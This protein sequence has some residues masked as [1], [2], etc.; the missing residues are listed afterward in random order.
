MS[1]TAL[2]VPVHSLAE[3]ISSE[4]EVRELEGIT[5]LAHT[6][7][8]IFQ[9]NP[10]RW[11]YYAACETTPPPGFKLSALAVY[12]QNGLAAAAPVFRVTYALDMPLQGRWRPLGE[13]LART[14]PRIANIPVIGLGSPLADACHI[15]FAQ[16]LSPAE[17]KRA[18]AHLIR[19]LEVIAAREHI[20]I[21]AIK[22][23]ETRDRDLLEGTIAEAG[24]TTT[25]AL[26]I[27][28][29][30]LSRF[31]SVDD[32]LA[33]LSAATRK[34]IRRKLKCPTTIRC[35]I[36]HDIAGIEQEIVS[37]YDETRGQSGVDYGDFEK[38][39]PAYFRAVLDKLQPN[40]HV[41]LYWLDSRLI[42]FN[43]VLL[44]R[45]RMIDKFI[46]LRYPVACE[47]SLY[48]RSWMENVRYCL[49]HG[50]SVLQ[51]GQTAYT[52]KVRYGSRLDPR[53]ICF[54][55]RRPFWNWVFAKA[56][57]MVAFDKMD[58]ELA[59]L[60]KRQKGRGAQPTASDTHP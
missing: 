44:D 2:T 57:P 49:A 54:K 30:D 43:L 58:P 56:A 23:L 27:A 4:L 11:E 9:D 41:M 16:H 60:A 20:D 15:R 59:S 32:Y 21:I 17:R 28:V 55:H 38:L 37:L 7:R 45:H 8:G 13:W 26:P 50:I 14:F 6:E 19:Q 40:A 12:D 51:T 34:D 36:R 53:W 39:S 47:H 10:E 29:L 48:V 46:G 18:T 22:D 31:K 3:E 25:S 24:F 33:S 52:T 1:Q 5:S 35:E 42:G